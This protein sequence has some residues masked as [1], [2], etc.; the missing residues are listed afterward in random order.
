MRRIFVQ[1]IRKGERMG[2]GKGK[3]KRRQNEKEK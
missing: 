2:G 1:E 3:E